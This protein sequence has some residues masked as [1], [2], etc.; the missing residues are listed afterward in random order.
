MEL[1]S[2]TAKMC[3][4]HMVIGADHAALEN[5]KEILGCVAVLVT[6]M[7]HIFLGAVIDGI[8]S[9]KLA[10]NA[11]VNGAF[12]GDKVRRAVNISNDKGAN[13]FGVDVG[14]MNAADGAFAFDQR[15]NG[16]L[17]CCGAICTITGLAAYICFIGFN[18]AA[19]AA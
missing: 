11:G 16:L 17:G 18:Y 13:G 1:A 15:D 14:N 5:G 2:V 6:A 10:T 9:A 4:A 3:F 19:T 8:V 12:I 7:L